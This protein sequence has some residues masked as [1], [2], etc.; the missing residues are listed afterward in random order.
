MRKYPPAGLLFRKVSKPY[1]VPE[2]DFTLEIGTPI[3][4]PVYSIQHDPE[5][6]PNPEMFDPDRFTPDKV[7]LRNPLEFLSFGDGPRNCIGARFG[8]MQTKVGLVMLLRHFKF[9]TCDET[10]VPL[11][12]SHTEFILAPKGGVTLRIGKI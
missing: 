6:Y 5:N 9:T 8:M 10:T 1:Y 4:I 11:E 12:I 3:W 2:Y 7:K